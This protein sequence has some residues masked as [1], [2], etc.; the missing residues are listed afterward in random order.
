M[1]DSELKLVVEDIKSA[2][3]AKSK[4]EYEGEDVASIKAAY[5]NKVIVLLEES[6]AV[7]SKL[8]EEVKDANQ[9]TSFKRNATSVFK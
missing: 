7:T 1:K 2:L 8:N 9:S 4:A 3:Y 6:D 5:Q